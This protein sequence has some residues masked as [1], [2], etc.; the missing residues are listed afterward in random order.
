[1]LIN[2]WKRESEWINRKFFNRLKEFEILWFI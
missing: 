1:M 2:F